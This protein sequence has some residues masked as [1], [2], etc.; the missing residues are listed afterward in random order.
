MSASAPAGTPTRKT[1]SAVAVWTSATSK[2]E[3]PSDPISQ[4][5]P[6]FC[7]HVPTLDMSCAS[8]SATNRR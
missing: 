4:T 5:A 6:T 2:A 8:H 1:G 7:I 3:P